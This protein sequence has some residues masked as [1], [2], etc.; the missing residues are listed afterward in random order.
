MEQAME[1]PH[2]LDGRN[3]RALVGK[4]RFSYFIDVCNS[5]SCNTPCTVRVHHGAQRSEK[6]VLLY[7]R[8]FDYSINIQCYH[9]TSPKSNE[10]R[11]FFY[12]LPVHRRETT[13]PR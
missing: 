1:S 6:Y 4:A 8:V 2:A 13:D 5:C 3:C 10:E 9:T 7:E 12:P 11:F